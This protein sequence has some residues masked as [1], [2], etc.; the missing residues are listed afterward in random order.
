LKEF[1]GVISQANKK[2]LE[3]LITYY[4]RCDRDRI[5]N[6][7][8][9]NFSIVAC[10][11]VAAVTFLPSRCLANTGD[12]HTDTQT[13]VEGFMKYAVELD[14]GGI[15]YTPN[16]IKTGSRFQKLMREIHRYTDSMV[17]T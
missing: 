1:S 14:S 3:E 7:T 17:I 2:F 6:D 9:N 4:T 16:F 11:L 10:V 8:S 13:D 15:I 12:K 5:E